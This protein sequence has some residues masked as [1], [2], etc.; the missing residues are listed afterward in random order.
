[1]AVAFDRFPGLTVKLLAAFTVSVY[2]WLPVRL[3]LLLSVALIV[4]EEEP[5]VVGVPLRT[6]VLE[7]IDSHD[8][9]LPADTAKV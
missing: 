6:P 1:M 7:F 5:V 8:G 4:K 3:V 2:A 9:R